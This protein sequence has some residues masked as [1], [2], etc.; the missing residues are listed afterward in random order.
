MLAEQL[1]RGLSS[2][3]SSGL[4]GAVAGSLAAL[5]MAMSSARRTRTSRKGFCGSGWP[6]T[7]LTMA[8][9]SRGR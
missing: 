9:F 2:I 5:L 6:C 7:S 8:G 4:I 3:I 1:G